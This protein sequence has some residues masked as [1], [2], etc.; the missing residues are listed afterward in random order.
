MMYWKPWSLQTSDCWP[1]QLTVSALPFLIGLKLCVFQIHTEGTQRAWFASF[2]LNFHIVS[3]AN[4]CR[5]TSNIDFPTSTSA[6]IMTLNSQLILWYQF[7]AFSHLI[8]L[9]FLLTIC[10]CLS[11]IWVQF[12]FL[13][14]QSAATA[15][16][17]GIGQPSFEAESQQGF[18]KLAKTQK[19]N[20]IFSKK[21]SIIS[22]IN[23]Y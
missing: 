3:S 4:F 8:T 11:V 14:S 10:H 9:I 23:K 6:F 7:W 1:R 16:S 18:P 5:L 19:V 15:R 21:W 13:F 12:S 2:L 22:Y 20:N 17:A